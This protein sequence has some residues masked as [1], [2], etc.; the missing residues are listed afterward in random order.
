MAVAMVQQV[1]AALGTLVTLA[2]LVRVTLHAVFAAL[3]TLVTT[4]RAMQSAD[5]PQPVV[6]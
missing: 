3:P 4:P 2:T 6:G 1:V 5:D